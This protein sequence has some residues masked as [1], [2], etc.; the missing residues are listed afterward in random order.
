MNEPLWLLDVE[1]T[2]PDDPLSCA[3]Q[4]R[5]LALGLGL[6]TRDAWA[7]SIAASELATNALKYGQRGRLRARA[8]PG[9][10]VELEVTDQGP[11]IS[12]LPSALADGYSRGRPVDFDLVQPSQGRGVGLGAVQRAADS[13]EFEAPPGGGLRVLF[14]RFKA[15]GSG[16]F[17]KG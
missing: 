8:L 17:E 13:L 12:D 3:T 10:G 4:C 15:G 1:L 2:E 6:D 9:P 16:P 11:G 14:R 5:T 7:V